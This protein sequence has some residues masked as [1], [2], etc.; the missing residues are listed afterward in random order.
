MR[1]FRLDPGIKFLKGNIEK[2]WNEDFKTFSYIRQSVTDEEIKEWHTMGY[3]HVKSFT[4][5]MYDNSNPLPKWVT[6]FDEIFGL[7]NQTYTFYVM[8]TL[9]IMPVH[10]DHYRS[11]INRF[12]PIPE[13]VSRIL[14]MLEDWKPGHYLE[15]N[16]TGFVNWRA[17]DFFFW[18]NDIQHA[19][20]NI[21]TDPRYTLQITGEVV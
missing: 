7:R 3:D 18:K 13:N 6:Q 12:D 16:G 11:Y 1:N 10:K 21:G 14:V 4:G 19:A 2:F 5:K 15:V 9:E 8:E 17:G 20:S